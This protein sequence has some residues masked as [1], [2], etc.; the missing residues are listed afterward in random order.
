MAPRVTAVL[1]ALLFVVFPAA[2]AATPVAPAPSG[3]AAQSTG[4]HSL[5]AE[6]QTLS[7][8]TQTLSAR[9]TTL[10]VQLR[11]DGD[12]EWRISKTFNITDANDTRAF[13]RL[14][15]E[16]L[17]GN[18]DENLLDTYRVAN[19]AAA[20]ATGR[21]MALRNV[22]RD[23]AVDAGEGRLIVSF[24]WTN[25][26]ATSGGRLLLQDAF[27]TPGG[28]WLN[29]LEPGNSLI[30]SPPPGYDLTNSPQNSYIERGDLRING[31]TTFGRGDLNIVYESD[32]GI[33]GTQ[34]GTGTN[35]VQGDFPLWGGVGLLLVVGLVAALLYLNDQDEL[36]AVGAASTDTDDGGD[37]PP[38]PE[39]TDDADEID[40][41][42]LSDEERVERL[43]TQNGGRMKQARIVRE[44]GWSNAKVSQ[45]LSAM[46][47][48]DRIDKLRIGRENLISFPDEDVTE[49]ED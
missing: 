47:E 22:S 7:S 21:D 20:Q 41:E 49:I 30:I 37:A 40:V 43:L 24:D 5:S 3:P 26:A 19:D 35:P 38:S 2:S 12:A 1:L 25:F 29:K 9:N 13:E 42:L 14:R 11:P 39:P 48:D 4:D 36:P 10:H 31:E 28:T 46:D 18:S 8:E 23:Y 34:T 16:F 33:N 27:Y 44:T 15:D 17:A 32:Q 45:L 6:T